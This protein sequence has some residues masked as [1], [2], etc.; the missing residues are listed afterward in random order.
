MIPNACSFRISCSA[1]NSYIYIYA[2]TWFADTVILLTAAFEMFGRISVNKNLDS[3]DILDILGLDIYERFWK[4][5][6]SLFCWDF[7]QKV[8]MS[9][10]FGSSNWKENLYLRPFTAR[11][12]WESVRLT[13]LQSTTSQVLNFWL[14][15]FPSTDMVYVTLIIP[16][17]MMSGTEQNSFHTTYWADE[18]L[19]SSHCIQKHCTVV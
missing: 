1:P 11:S 14:C 3:N 15:A 8:S 9:Y 5:K 18:L 12:I 13:K 16:A 4:M 10:S 2:A 17:A 6:N 19:L 7:N